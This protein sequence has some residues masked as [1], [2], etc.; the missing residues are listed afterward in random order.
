MMRE[1]EEDEEE[2]EAEKRRSVEDERHDLVI[3]GAE[4]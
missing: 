3:I 1:M 4:N 2:S